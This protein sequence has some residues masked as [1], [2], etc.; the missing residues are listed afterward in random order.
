[1][2]AKLGGIFAPTPTDGPHNTRELLPLCLILRDRLK[3]ARTYKK[4]TTILM[5]RLVKIDGKTRVDKCYPAG[6]MGEYREVPL[7]SHPIARFSGEK[8]DPM[9]DR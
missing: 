7:S 3:Y 8:K 5:Q 1:M 9:A 4:G 2:L 6:F